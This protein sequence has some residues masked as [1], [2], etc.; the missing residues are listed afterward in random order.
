M[1]VAQKIHARLARSYR[2]D[3]CSIVVTASIG[4]AVYPVDGAS[5]SD[6]LQRA[7]CAM[8]RAKSGRNASQRSSTMVPPQ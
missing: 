7:D 6:L 5:Q 1:A 8:Y 2:V 4:V 3:D